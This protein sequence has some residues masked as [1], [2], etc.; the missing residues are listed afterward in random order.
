MGFA[1]AKDGFLNGR[2]LFWLWRLGWAVEF[3]GLLYTYDVRPLLRS[4]EGS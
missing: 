4:C 1:C 2:G 3:R